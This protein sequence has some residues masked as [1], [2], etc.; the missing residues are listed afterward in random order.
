MFQHQRENSRWM[1]EGVCY[2][3]AKSYFRDLRWGDRHRDERTRRN[4]CSACP[5]DDREPVD[6]RFLDLGCDGEPVDPAGAV[7]PRSWLGLGPSAPLAQIQLAQPPVVG[8][9][10]AS[11]VSLTP[12]GDRLAGPTAGLA[13]R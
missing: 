13:P 12:C 3:E 1:H 8:R 4:A 11:L 5:D 7:A 2:V 9:P 6:C 10:L